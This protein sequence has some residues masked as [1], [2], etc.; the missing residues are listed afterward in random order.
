MHTQFTH[1]IR[2][3][4]YEVLWST[5]VR[6]ILQRAPFVRRIFD[7]WRRRHPFDATYGVDTSGVVPSSECAPTT[8]MASRISPYAGSQ[9]S[10][11]RATLAALPEHRAYT[12]VDLGCGKG[13]ALIV[14]S[15]FPFH[16]LLGVDISPRLTAT[17][18]ANA[19]RIAG[20]YPARTPIEVETG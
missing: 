5:P 6:S 10:I 20:K 3:K 15:E 1:R 17:A 18:R 13:R 9:P 12:F 8:T 4:A 16:K 7:G 11:V 19:A 2:R 14:A